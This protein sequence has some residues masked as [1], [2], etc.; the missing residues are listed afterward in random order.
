MPRATDSFEALVDALARVGSSAVA[1]ATGA[2]AV[3]HPEI[4]YLS[5]GRRFCGRALTV[6]ADNSV[7]AVMAAIREA[8]PGDVLCVLGQDGAVIGEF[9]ALECE[10][11]GLRA[12]V[13]DGRVRDIAV[14]RGLDLP[15]F[16]RGPVPYAAPHGS[17]GVV[18]EGVTLGGVAV[19]PGDWVIGDDDG[20]VCVPAGEVT[21]VLAKAEA[22]LVSEARL[23]ARMEAGE[24]MFDIL[25][26]ARDPGSR[27]A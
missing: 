17:G 15:I 27:G 18:Q 5:G 7:T 22:T 26:E 20:I 9:L 3:V 13:I 16:A 8:G 19:Q 25:A 1:D 12:L 2:S 11:R 4:A 21:D 24:L 23:R 6:D 14:L 10:R